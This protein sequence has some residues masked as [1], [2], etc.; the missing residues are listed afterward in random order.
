MGLARRCFD[1]G[2]ISEWRS[3]IIK[4]FRFTVNVECIYGV[5]WFIMLSCWHAISLYT[6]FSSN[7]RRAYIMVDSAI[8]RYKLP[9]QDATIPY[10]QL[11]GT[12][13]GDTYN[14]GSTLDSCW[15]WIGSHLTENFPSMCSS[16]SWKTGL[17]RIAYF[18]ISCLPFSFL[19]YKY[20]YRDPIY[21][22]LFLAFC[23]TNVM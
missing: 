17:C 16:L 5:L 22:L 12:S 20:N 8:K 9:H 4:A 1:Y 15:H 6:L 23:S 18:F 21:K 13:W 3:I 7:N 19:T 11:P 2:K 14:S 10:P